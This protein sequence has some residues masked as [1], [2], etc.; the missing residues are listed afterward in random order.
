MNSAVPQKL[1]YIVF[2]AYGF[3]IVLSALR[4]YV[5]RDYPIYMNVNEIPSTREVFLEWV[6]D[7][8]L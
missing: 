1:W 5:N 8:H 4:I 2:I 3:V 6:K 7:F